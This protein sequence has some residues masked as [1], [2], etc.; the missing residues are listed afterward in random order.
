MTSLLDPQEGR[1]T[2]R[3]ELHKL[4]GGFIRDITPF[5]SSVQAFSSL[6]TP[7]I[8]VTVTVSDQD[9]IMM[10]S[11]IDG[12]IAVVFNATAGN[13]KNLKGKFHINSVSTHVQNNRKSNALMLNC[14]GMEHINNASQK[15]QESRFW[16]NRRPISEIVRFI[17]SKYLRITPSVLHGTLGATNINIPKLHPLEAITML[18]QR[19]RGPGKCLYT[20]Y[21]RFNESGTPEYRFEDLTFNMR[22]GSKWNLVLTEGNYREDADQIDDEYISGK[23]VSKITHMGADTFFNAHNMIKQGYPSRSYVKMDFVNKVYEVIDDTSSHTLIGKQQMNELSNLVKSTADP[24][25]N[26]VL[27]EPF[28]GDKTY[29][30]DDPLLENNF[31]RGRAV[32]SGLTNK[33]VTVTT[34]GCPEIGPGDVVEITAPS[35]TAQ[36]RDTDLDFNKKYLVYAAEH[37]FGGRTNKK[38]TTKLQL[39]SDGQ[40]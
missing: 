24:Y 19:A 33:R 14:I 30:K 13:Y 18:C 35:F 25:Y 3:I 5:V 12:D 20:F 26:R 16:Y 15:V 1:L 11:E 29:Y 28:N 36:K 17:C 9:E 23:K 4:T 34:Y 21:Q 38:F 6:D 2:A 22:S 8:G 39:A 27:Y 37:F 40:R 7:F 32:A 10:N 31:R